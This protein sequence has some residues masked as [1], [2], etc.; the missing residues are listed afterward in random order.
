M[1][2]KPLQIKEYHFFIILTIIKI[3]H[4]FLIVRINELSWLGIKAS[5]VIQLT[6]IYL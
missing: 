2:I 5:F 1:I 4:F 3:G 6:D